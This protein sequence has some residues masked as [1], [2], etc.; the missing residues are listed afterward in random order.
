ML[1]ELSGAS[2]DLLFAPHG[3]PD[4]EVNGSEH[5]DADSGERPGPDDDPGRWRGGGQHFLGELY[6]DEDFYAEDGDGNPGHGA[7]LVALG[8]GDPLV[9]LAQ[10]GQAEEPHNDEAPEHEHVRGGMPK[11]V[12]QEEAIEF[13]DGGEENEEHDGE[14]ALGR[15]ENLPLEARPV[16]GPER[17]RGGGRGRAI[18]GNAGPVERAHFK[19]VHDEVAEE[20]A[21][22]VA[23]QNVQNHLIP[24][25]LAEVGQQM[26]QRELAELEEDGPRPADVNVAE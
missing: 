20:D 13:N 19:V 12:F 2:F 5:D 7:E 6:P 4:V 10:C 3:F 26:C 16:V 15:R 11:H 14:E 1:C 18:F 24:P 25:A 23:K 8:I 21:D 22:R 9:V 17:A